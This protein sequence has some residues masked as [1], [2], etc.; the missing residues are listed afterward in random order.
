MGQVDLSAE[1]AQIA[2]QKPDAVFAHYAGGMAVNFMKQFNQAG[3]KGIPLITV[4][5]LDGLSLPAIKDSALGVRVS[6]QMWAPDTKNPENAAFV[7]SFEKEYGRIPSN[8]AA[9]GYD[10]AALLDSAIG[11]VRGDLTNKEAFRSALKEADFK[12]VRGSFKFNTNQFPIENFYILEVAKD[13]KGR[14][15][16]ITKDLILPDHEDPFAAQC[17]LK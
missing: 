2:V 14:V 11:K 13:Q 16:L 5:S 9:Q 10:A 8:H 7:E 15:S 6:A 12:S 4:A 1:L 17:P 3:L